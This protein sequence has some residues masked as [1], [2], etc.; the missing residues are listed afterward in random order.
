MNTQHCLIGI[1][2]IVIPEDYRESC[3]GDLYELQEQRIR[4][5]KAGPVRDFFLVYQQCLFLCAGIRMRF[6]SV[7]DRIFPRSKF[8]F[9]LESSMQEKVLIYIVTGTLI[10]LICFHA[11]SFWETTASTLMIGAID[12]L[13]QSSQIEPIEQP[14]WSEQVTAPQKRTK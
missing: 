5:S 9:A 4:K 2:S 6:D 12:P 1:A 8:S 10:S 7:F 14:S 11:S 13:P 3:I